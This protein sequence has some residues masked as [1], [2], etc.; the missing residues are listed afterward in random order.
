MGDVV[1]VLHVDDDPDFLS[2]TA[3]VL[4]RSDG[5]LVVETATSGPNALERLDSDDI[6]CVVS[7]YEM[8]G[9]TGIELLDAV[10][11]DHPE[12]P[13]ILFTGRGSEEVASDAISAGVTDYLQKTAG[14]GQFA[15]LVNRIRHAVD[16]Y[17]SHHALTAERSKRQSLY[18]NLPGLAYRCRNDPAWPMETIGGQVEA[19]TG[20]AAKDLESGAVSWG[21]DLIHPDDREEVWETVQSAVDRN[22][23][24]EIVYRIVKPDDT[25]RWVRERGRLARDRDGELVIDGFIAD[26]TE[27][28]RREAELE[29]IERRYEAIFN[30]PISFMALLRPDGTVISVNRDALSFVEASEA[31]V[32]GRPFWETPW[33]SHDVELQAELRTWIESA[34]G[35]ELVRFEADHYAPDGTKVTVDGVIHPIRDRSDAVVELLAAGRDISERRRR[36]Q[37]LEAATKRYRRLFE[38]HRDAIL[39]ADP[40]RRIVDCNP[41]FTDLFGYEVEEIRDEHTAV[42]Y[43]DDDGFERM[44]RLLEEDGNPNFFLT[45][46]YETRDGE[47]F[48]GETNVFALEDDAGAVQA[49]VGAIRDVSDRLEREQQLQRE[50]DRL[51]SFASVVSHDLRNPLGVAQGRLDLVREECAS[52]H[53]DQLGLSL[54]RMDSLI[55]DLLT[56]ARDGEAVSDLDPVN[57]GT[58]A[59]TCWSTVGAQGASISVQTDRRISADESRLRE[60][61]EN[62]Y[63]N[64]IEHAGPPVTITVGDIEDGFYVADDG[65][66]IPAED[67]ERAFEAGVTTTE[68]GTG[69]G[70]SIVREIAAAHGWSVRITDADGGG[71]RFEFT[72]LE[73]AG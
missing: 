13:F 65:P 1:R 55:D 56:L 45:V 32:V 51:E 2:L 38:S 68:D 57:L 39:V 8:P 35:G 70:L 44:G 20:H 54:E 4:E 25:V 49:I 12:L 10:R 15:V 19:L 72:G 50:R 21:E 73:D 24:F 66:G 71:A 37:E 18:D 60:L 17:R 42:L 62:L 52:E 5:D 48:P 16:R 9:M 3:D 41:A 6:D 11:E 26:I 36:E 58:I 14:T 29:R 63:R 69:F 40:D 46:E 33:W 31:A 30:N 64:A 27:Q 67:R 59:D 47:V 7:D 34:A 61:F 43:A 53:L 28:R 22:E 23:P